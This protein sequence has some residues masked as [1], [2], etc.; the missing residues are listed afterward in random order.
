MNRKI[1]AI[2]A[3][4]L[5][6]AMCASL[7]GCSNKSDDEINES[8][9]ESHLE[10]LFGGNGGN[11]A[12]SV[13]EASKPEPKPIDP[14]ENLEVVFEG[15]SPL[16]TAKLK[17]ENSNVSYSLSSDRELENGDKITVTAEI[18]SYI[19]DQFVLTT[20]SK[21]FTVSDRPYYIMKLSDLTDDDIKKLDSKITE[22]VLP[23]I[24][25][26]NG[27][28]EGSTVNSL[29]F[30]GNINLVKNGCNYCLY[31]VYKANVTFAKAGVTKDYIFSAYFDHIYKEND[32]TLVFTDGK[33]AYHSSGDMSLSLNGFYVGGAF[34]SVDSLNSYVRRFGAEIESN[35]K[36]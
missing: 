6:A 3:A 11:N 27:G 12:A 7:T 25:S 35:V 17:G 23:D 21:E 10:S 18:P 4:L 36:E 32:G 33:P 29:D 20:D 34:A 19:A 1:K 26:H 31:F 16:V 28:G 8:N 2:S 24:V 13:P 30:I 14:F 22:L 9:I 5:A 15:I